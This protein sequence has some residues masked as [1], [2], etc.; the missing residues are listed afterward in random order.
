MERWLTSLKLI[1]KEDPTYE[2]KWREYEIANYW[3]RYDW[4]DRELS[5]EDIE[6]NKDSI[7]RGVQK[8]RDK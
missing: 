3:R 4:G 2:D 1:S 6:A 7:I 8:R 5:E